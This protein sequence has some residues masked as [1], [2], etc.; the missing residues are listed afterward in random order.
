MFK[1]QVIVYFSHSQNF[2]FFFL[3]VIIQIKRLFKKLR[4]YRSQT[5]IVVIHLGTIA[6]HLF[7][8]SITNLHLLVILLEIAS[9]PNEG[10]TTG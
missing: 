4:K 3:K 10:G 9:T 5:K 7:D 6:V 8:I 1:A 2:S